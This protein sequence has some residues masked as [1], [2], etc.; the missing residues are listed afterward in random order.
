MSD[1]VFALCMPFFNNHGMLAQH[2]ENWEAYPPHLKDGIEISICDDTSDIPIT[3]EGVGILQHLHRISPPKVIW[4][5]CCATNI[6]VWATSAPWI[7]LTDI[8]HIVTQETWDALLAFDET[9]AI[10]PGM[11]YTFQRMNVDLTPYKPHPNSWLMHRGLWETCKGHDE[12][13]RGLYN[14]DH[15]FRMRLERVARGFVE[16]PYSLVRVGRESIPDASTPRSYL[17][18]REQD[19]ARVSAMRGEFHRAG[20]FWD[21]TRLRAPFERIW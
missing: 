6:A 18:N 21:D 3:R 5:Q 15:S 10:N 11:V 12:R 1:P 2:R 9:Q 14:Q 8:D 16:L 17:A 4:S 13:Y 19:K 20:T 7:V